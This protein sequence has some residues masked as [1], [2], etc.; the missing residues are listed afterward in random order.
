MDLQNARKKWRMPSVM[1]TINFN[2]TRACFLLFTDLV[3]LQVHLESIEQVVPL[4]LVLVQR[5]IGVHDGLS[6]R[7]QSRVWTKKQG[8]RNLRSSGVGLD[9]IVAA[10]L[11]GC[12]AEGA[13]GRTEVHGD[14]R[15]DESITGV[16]L[17]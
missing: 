7:V 2:Q 1:H 17:R 12:E 11:S 9:M 8:C 5:V 6:E 16:K 4:R 14:K 3:V 13:V 15:V 10:F